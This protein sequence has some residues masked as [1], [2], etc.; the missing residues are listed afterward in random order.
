MMAALTATA[1][2]YGE[3]WRTSAGEKRVGRKRGERQRTLACVGG[4]AREA[5]K[6]L[7]LGAEFL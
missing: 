7:G 6:S 2:N 5:L 4:R 3:R 1:V